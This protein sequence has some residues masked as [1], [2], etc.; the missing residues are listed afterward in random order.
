MLTTANSILQVQ[1]VEPLQKV[2]YILE[3]ELVKIPKACNTR[4][5]LGVLE[6]MTLDKSA[7]KLTVR[8]E[9]Q[10]FTLQAG[11]SITNGAAAIPIYECNTYE[12]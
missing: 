9:Y 6:S 5:N 4:H 10:G 2:P 7:H 11:L 3:A 12:Q 1:T 8:Y